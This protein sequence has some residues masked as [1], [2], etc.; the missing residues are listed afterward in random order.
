MT[1]PSKP[2]FDEEGYWIAP[3]PAPKFPIREQGDFEREAER[4][5]N[6][7]DI[8]KSVQARMKENEQEGVAS[9]ETESGPST[10]GELFDD[11]ASHFPSD[12]WGN[13]PSK[14][15]ES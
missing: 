11:I 6:P 13:L 9:K 5:R 12:P 8:F 10:A 7:P 4:L 3:I 15:K 2:R 1:P 14:K